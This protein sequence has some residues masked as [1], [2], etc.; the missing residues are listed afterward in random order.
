[1]KAPT[2]P[3][4]CSCESRFLKPLYHYTESPPKEIKFKLPQNTS[5]SRDI[6]KCTLCN[7]FVSL[8]SMDINSMYS[9][10]YVSSNYKDIDGIKNTFQKIINLP[11]EKSDNSGRIN[12]VHNF[13]KN[14]YQ[15]NI[16]Q[17]K[18]LDIGSGLCV[19]LYKMKELGWE[20]TALDPDERSAEHARK[21]VGVN[22]IHG[23]FL[24]LEKLDEYDLITMN[25][26]LEHVLYPVD[27]L[28]K[29]KKFL[30][31]NGI[32]YLELPDGEFA[33]TEGQDREEFTI[34]HPH[35][36]SITSTAMLIQRAGFQLLKLERLQEPST[37]FTIRAFIK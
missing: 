8:H 11:E 29:A 4:N 20:C 6:L 22:S 32:I 17:R 18:V 12:F 35:N 31:K 37:K 5:Y 13:A 16:N 25:K 19:F 10:N 34:D 14:Y 26:V 27:M 3:L 15:S 24:E 30:K 7:H 23:D 33:E 28:S 21:T 1:M 36:F 2:P 9:E